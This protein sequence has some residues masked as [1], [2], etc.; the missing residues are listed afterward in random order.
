MATAE[1]NTASVGVSIDKVPK[2]S[3]APLNKNGTDTVKIL[4]PAKRP[5][6]IP[7]L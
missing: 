7:T 2:V 6:E 4:E 1:D 5:N 3:T